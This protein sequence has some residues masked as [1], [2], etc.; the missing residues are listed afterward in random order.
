MQTPQG[1]RP[2]LAAVVT[3]YRKYSHAQH[4]VDRQ[5][6]GYGWNG[7]YHRPPFELVSLYVDQVGDDDLSRERASRLPSMKIYP[8]IREALSRGGDKLAVDGVVLVGEHGSY[9]RNER[10]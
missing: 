4:I 9:R 7:E 3:V 10:G 8:T 6:D 2:K 5:L 1:E